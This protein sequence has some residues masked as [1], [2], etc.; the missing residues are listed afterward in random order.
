MGGPMAKLKKFRC[1]R[2]GFEFSDLDKNIS[3]GGVGMMGSVNYNIPPEPKCPQCES[4]E[5]EKLD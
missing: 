1:R 4:L 3:V 5:L 2:C